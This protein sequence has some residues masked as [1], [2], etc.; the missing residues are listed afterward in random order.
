M[1]VLWLI[2]L[3]LV[4]ALLA[5]RFAGGGSALA[6]DSVSGP[7][8]VPAAAATQPRPVSPPIAP[9]PATPGGTPVIE[10]LARAEA[11]RKILWAGSAVYLDSA[12][13]SPDS[14]LQRWDER[15]EIRIGIQSWADNPTLVGEVVAAVREWRSL[16]VGMALLET[17]DTTDV[18]IT[19]GWTKSFEAVPVGSDSAGRT[20]LTRLETSPR[21]QILHAE[22]TLAVADPKGRPLS[23]AQVR[24]IAMHELGHALGLP[25]SNDPADIM[26]PTVRRP[27]LSSRDRSTISLLYSLAP[28]A[29]REPATP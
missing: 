9:P 8:T 26:Y 17:T 1:R 20:G 7:P 16:G 13:S 4:G 27:S 29:L 24:A 5:S 15:P 3:L 19:V 21:G 23:A 2:V 28:G 6:A 14:I 11:R 10:R 22:I 25:H 12:F 18:Q